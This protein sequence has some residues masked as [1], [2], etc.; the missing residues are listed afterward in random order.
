MKDK[1]DKV[2]AEVIDLMR[3]LADRNV[4]PSYTISALVSATITIAG[5]LDIDM[6]Y[7]VDK[8]MQAEAFRKEMM[9]SEGKPVH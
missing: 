7:I 2:E 3:Y 4:E 9:S 6:G 1:F 5:A 8:M